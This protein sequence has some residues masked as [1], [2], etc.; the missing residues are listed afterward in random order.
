MH[1]LPHV[2][3]AGTPTWNSNCKGCERMPH[4][5]PVICVYSR[6]CLPLIM[7]LSINAFPMFPMAKLTDPETHVK[8]ILKLGWANS[9][10]V[11]LPFRCSWTKFDSA[12]HL[13]TRSDSNNL[14]LLIMSESDILCVPWDLTADTQVHKFCKAQASVQQWIR[15]NEYVSFRVYRVADF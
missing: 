8:S 14:K 7:R 9:M 6:K 2:P 4:P 1:V 12:Q 5:L 3:E 11:H 13:D 10:F 15:K